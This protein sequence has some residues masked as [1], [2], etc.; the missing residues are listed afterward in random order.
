MTTLTAENQKHPD[1]LYSPEALNERLFFSQLNEPGYD[2][3]MKMWNILREK[4]YRKNLQSD[5]SNS[6][7]ENSE[8]TSNSDSTHISTKRVFNSVKQNPHFNEI[9]SLVNKPKLY[10]PRGG[11]KGTRVCKK[12]SNKRRTSKS[13]RRTSRKYK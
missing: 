5:K 7:K 4:S 8:S 11:R 9:S 12:K 10:L 2:E 13:S 6:N 1:Y 3:K